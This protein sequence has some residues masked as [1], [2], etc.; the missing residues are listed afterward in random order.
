M[1][2]HTSLEVFTHSKNQWPVVLVGIYLLTCYIY[3]SLLEIYLPWSTKS[4]IFFPNRMVIKQLT[5]GNSI[6]GLDQKYLKRI[7]VEKL[8][9]LSSRVNSSQSVR[10]VWIITFCAGIIS[11]IQ[12]ETIKNENKTSFYPIN[13][14]LGSTFWA[15]AKHNLSVDRF[16]KTPA[17]NS[18]KLKIQF[19]L[20]IFGN[21][22]LFL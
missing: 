7:Q 3:S 5:P 9:K 13:A 15:S 4:L 21:W 2:H 12:C 20:N 8:V 11:N 6:S 16:A 18:C 14:N 10:S 22:L 1:Y 19:N 17:V